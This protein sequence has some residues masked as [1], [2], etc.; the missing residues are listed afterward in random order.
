MAAGAK[1]IA[2]HRNI[3]PDIVQKQDVCTMLASE[4][5][6][7]AAKKMKEKNIAAIIVVDGENKPIGI[8]TERDLTYR[9]LAKE[10]DAAKVRLND[11]M[12]ASPDTL[13]PKDTAGDALELMQIRR[14]RHLPV[15]EAERVLA[16]V[17][18]RDLFAAVKD[19]LEENIR[20]T[21]AF[22]FGDRYGT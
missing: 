12:T 13:A 5:A 19:D 3:I 16:V 10:L 4:T 21:E 9:V 18:I 22:V 7:K 17:S 20:E 1:E 15:V 11:I 6:L 8:V 14:Y 2:M